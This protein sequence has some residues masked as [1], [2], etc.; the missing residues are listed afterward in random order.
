[1]TAARCACSTTGASP[2]GRYG[3]D[4]AESDIETL[5]G[6]V[7]NLGSDAAAVMPDSMRIE[8][9]QPSSRAG[10]DVFRDL[11]RYMDSQISK[12]VLGQTMTTDDGSSRAQAEVHNAVRGD[13]LAA[14]ARQLAATLQRDLIAPFTRLNFGAD[15]APPRLRFAGAPAAPQD[16][17]G[18][19]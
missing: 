9:H 18:R 17:T 6:A 3:P 14:D 10:A 8:F 5:M 19:G 16:A 12:A 2:A 1:M 7:A 13:I 11:A 15:A 4:A